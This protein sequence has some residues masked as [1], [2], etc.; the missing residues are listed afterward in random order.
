MKEISNLTAKISNSHSNT[1]NRLQFKN[2]TKLYHLLNV[3]KMTVSFTIV[4]SVRWILRLRWCAR[5]G[6]L[7]QVL[8]SL[9]QGVQKNTFGRRDSH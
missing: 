4:S 9:E 8:E 6:G 2:I 3:K 7:G 1:K 5:S